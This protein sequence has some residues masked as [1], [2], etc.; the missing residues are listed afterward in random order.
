[1]ALVMKDGIK[2]AVAW[3]N[4]ISG[5][6]LLLAIIW[7]CWS[8]A[9]IFWLFLAPPLAPALPVAEQQ[10]RQASTTNTSS[11]L[12]IF[13][14]P[15]SQAAAT[16][17][18]PQVTL[19]GVMI[20][21]P[22]SLSSAMLEFEGQ[23]LNYRIG[24]A[25]GD[26]G[27]RLIDVSW[28]QV[29]IANDS[30]NQVVIDMPPP[31]N[32]N[33][34]INSNQAAA[35]D[36]SNRRLPDGSVA[37]NIGGLTADNRLDE[38]FDPAALDEADRLDFEMGAAMTEQASPEPELEDTINSASAA[39]KQNP[40]GYLS[41][42]GVAA[43]GDGYE[44]TGSMPAKIRERL[45][46]EPGDRVMSV[47]GQRVGNDPAQ[48]ADLLQQVKRSGEAQIEVKRGEQTINIRQQF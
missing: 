36:I 13:M 30:D 41:Q 34:D 46:L 22:D 5:W 38:Q 19:K 15:P 32:M 44:V 45:G 20:A 8:L 4:R 2:T 24:K 11:A 26:S 1:M 28:N 43:S 23:V 25:I 3:I 10:T 16:T 35:G 21:T 14:T 29:I 7:L 18:P 47:N 48:D 17:P 40:A 27:Y 42:M 33:Q 6:L 31:L 9:R 39:L 12:N 37:P